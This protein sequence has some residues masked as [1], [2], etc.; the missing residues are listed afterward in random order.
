MGKSDRSAPN[1]RWI[2]VLTG[3]GVLYW[4]VLLSMVVTAN[5]NLFPTLLLLG[6]LVAPLTVLTYLNWPTGDS[7]VDGRLVAWVAVLSGVLGVLAAGVLEYATATQR[8]QWPML[9]VAVI[10]ETLKIL[11]PIGALAFASRAV[12]DARA[13]LVIGVAS[14]AG[15]AVLETMGYGFTT[16]L[17]SH[18]LA[19]VD[20]ILLVRGVFAPA[21]H[22]AW[23]GL[24]GASLWNFRTRPVGRALL[25][26][27]ATYVVVVLLHALWDTL[28]AS[29]LAHVLIAAVSV[30]LLVARERRIPSGAVR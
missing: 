3:T 2:L 22:L 13:G 12:T 11:V 15:F 19:A 21:C 8:S 27:V 30:L 9:T 25:G 17:T 29:W 4:L 23:T 10:E 24:L 5:P 16:L 7:V 26:F 6:A 28:S 1:W 18:S 14:G 20:Q